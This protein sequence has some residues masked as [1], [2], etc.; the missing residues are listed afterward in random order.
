M[1]ALRAIVELWC[2]HCYHANWERENLDTQ[3]KPAA[4]VDKLW[5]NLQFKNFSKNFK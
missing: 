5:L 3:F 4:K 1:K 2:G